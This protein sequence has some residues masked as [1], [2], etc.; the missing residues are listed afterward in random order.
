MSGR[1]SPTKGD[2]SRANRISDG[3]TTSRKSTPALRPACTWKGTGRSAGCRS[4]CARAGATW[5][6]AIGARGR[7]C[8]SLSVST[9]A[10]QSPPAYSSREPGPI[11]DR[12]SRSTASRPPNP[13][14]CPLIRREAGRCLR[15][16]DCSGAS[17]SAA[18]GSSSAIWRRG[19]C[20]ATPRA[21]RSRNAGRTITRVRA[22]RTGFDEDDMVDDLAHV[23]LPQ[24]FF[25]PF[26]VAAGIYGIRYVLLAG[27][28][29]LF[30]YA[31]PGGGKLQSAM[32]RGVQIRREIAY[33]AVAVLIFGLVIGLISGYGIAPHTLLY[34]EVARYG[35]AYFWLSIL[36]VIPA[37]DTYFYWTHRLMPTPPL[38]RAFQGVDQLSRNPTP[39]TA[40]AL[41]PLESVVQ[42]LGLVLIM[43]IIPMH[44]SAL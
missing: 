4:R 35:W 24:G 39:W 12:T 17:T 10:A 41:H 38:V 30:W 23:L 5:S 15:P 28:A 27:M 29:F 21:A 37:S 9:A 7:T 25:K 26:L 1:S 31:R 40:Y 36:L 11:R 22:W 2:A 42:A 32:P 8:A 34:T 3:D 13:P 43:F 18:N 20:K 16:A 6:T 14:T 33:S 44:P 19:G